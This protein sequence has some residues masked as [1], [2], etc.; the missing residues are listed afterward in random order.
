MFHNLH[1]T[2]YSIL[3]ARFPI[4]FASHYPKHI[5]ESAIIKSINSFLRASLF[6][7]TLF[8][9]IHSDREGET[10]RHGGRSCAKSDGTK[11]KKT[12][13]DLDQSVSAAIQ[14]LHIYKH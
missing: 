7:G 4:A 10:E 11:D 12:A 5:Q 13:M 2:V 9:G 14:A 8:W 6:W 3:Y 1:L